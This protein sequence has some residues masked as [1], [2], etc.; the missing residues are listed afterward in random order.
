MW[1]LNDIFRNTDVRGGGCLRRKSVSRTFREG[2][3]DYEIIQGGVVIHPRLVAAKHHAS[4][5]R[6]SSL[7]SGIANLDAMLAG[8]LRKWIDRSAA[9]T[10]G[11]GQIYNRHAVYRRCHAGMTQSGRLHGSMKSIETLIERVEKTV[12]LSK[13]AVC[14]SYITERGQSPC[15][16][17]TQRKCPGSIR[18]R[19]PPSRRSGR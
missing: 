11:R 12:F 8:G 4:F 7:P 9:R 17:L 5:T 14:A 10:G 15:A 13:D 1:S 3:H 18:S 6:V 19:S 16:Q 2:Y